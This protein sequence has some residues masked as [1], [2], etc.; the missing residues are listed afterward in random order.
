MTKQT[1]KWGYQWNSL[2][3]C[4]YSK[5]YLGVLTSEYHDVSP[6]LQAGVLYFMEQREVTLR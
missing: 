5:A 1:L 4:N 6:R 2:V 3:E